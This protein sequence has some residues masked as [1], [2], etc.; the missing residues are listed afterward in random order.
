MAAD[1]D[2][3]QAFSEDQI[4]RLTGISI[5]QLRYWDQTNF[6]KPTFA[7]P[8]RRV[9]F[10]RIYSF[11]D[12]VSLRVLNVLRNQYSV[13]LQHLRGVAE[14]LHDMSEDKWGAMHLFVMNRR[15]VFAELDT[16]TYREI[17]SRQYVIPIALGSVVADTRKDIESLKRRGYEDIGRVAKIA[18]HL[19]QLVGHRGYQDT[20]PC[21]EAVRRGRLFRQ[22]DFG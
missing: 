17:V 4:V 9:A 12:L 16:R 15:V 22:P 7:E 8:N 13:S 20:C 19:P 21:G 10:S 3:V 6:F 18:Q 5:R 14:N 11:T 1:R 2:I